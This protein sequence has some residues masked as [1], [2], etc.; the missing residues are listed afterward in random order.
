VSIY[1]D[2]WNSVLIEYKATR[3]LLNRHLSECIRFE[4]GKVHELKN[5]KASELS[6][7]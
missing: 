3:V 5:E 4:Y 1:V 7:L 6:A 2:A